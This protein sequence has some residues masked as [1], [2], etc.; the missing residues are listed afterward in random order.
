[1][2]TLHVDNGPQERQLLVAFFD[3]TRFL[4]FCQSHTAREVVGVLSAYYELVGDIIEAAGGTVV[5]FMGDAGLIAF[6]EE[7]VDE[8]VLALKRLKDTGDAWLA[9]H[10]A[11]SQAIIKAHFGPV[12]C[13][14][15]GSRK[16]KRLDIFGDTVNTAATMSSHGIALSPQ[17]FRMLDAATRKLFKKHTPPVTYIPVDEPHR[18]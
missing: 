11:Q 13:A 4:R 16:D 14:R 8:G 7:H 9:D 1:M 5:K 15:V 3:L 2:N 10:G 6:P 12:V 17:A 18:E